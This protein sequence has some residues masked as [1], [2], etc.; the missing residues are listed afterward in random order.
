M[1]GDAEAPVEQEKLSKHWR[2]E[3]PARQLSTKE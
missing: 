2:F 3:A 1:A